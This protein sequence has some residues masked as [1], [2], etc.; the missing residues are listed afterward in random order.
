MNVRA[1]SLASVA[2]RPARNGLLPDEWRPYVYNGTG[3]DIYAPRPPSG[4][5]KA[6]RA[7]KPGIPGRV[8]A[9]LRS[10][11]GEASTPE[12]WM[13]MELDGGPEF[14]S[15][16]LVQVL[17][18]LARRDP[19]AVSLAG[20][21]NFGSGRAARWQLEPGA[22][23]VPVARTRAATRPAAPADGRCRR[24]GYLRSVQGHKLACGGAA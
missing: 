13:A 20:R 22:D 2:Q 23:S 8:I 19:P 7:R 9:A 16:Y 5:E 3:V 11:G 10:L 14:H 12:I 21:E 1:V 15:G 6:A 18:R 4:A 24:C 17:N